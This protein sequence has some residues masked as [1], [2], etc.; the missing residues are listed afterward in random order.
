PKR[1][2]RTGDQRA[3][4]AP[5]G[6]STDPAN[7]PIQDNSETLIWSYEEDQA[8]TFFNQPRAQIRFV[9]RFGKNDFRVE[10]GG[11]DLA[12][13]QRRAIERAITQPNLTEPPAFGA[14]QQAQAAPVAEA[15][16]VVQ[17]DLTTEAFKNAVAQLKGSGK[18]DNRAFVATGEFVTAEGETFVPV[19]VYVPKSSGITPKEGQTFFGVIE[20][21]NGKS[22]L[23]FEE[24]AKLTASRDDYFV[25]KSITLP[26]GKHRGYFGIAE[27]GTPVVVT[28]VDM[29]L[30]G[31]LDKDATAASQLILSN[32]V[33]PLTEAQMATDPFAF[34]GLKV[35]PKADKTFRP[36]DEL[37]YFVELRNPGLPEMIPTADAPAPLPN[38]Q[39]KLDVEGTETG[40]KK[41]KRPAPPMEIEAI[42]L[43]GVPG[44]YGVGNAIP[45]S[46][47][48]PGEYTF[49]VKIIDTIKKESYTLS[50]KFKVVE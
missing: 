50:E 46:S 37:W 33:Y 9:D 42:P 25:D 36:A 40:G 10:R 26:A 28:A 14:P 1:I 48:K 38:I 35:V 41:V 3:G 49:T 13:A 44:H 12:A 8:R 2:Q 21:A 23:A 20:D 27:N 19:S 24:P 16:P 47:F 32:N 39:V 4:A 30:K 5:S 22:V 29:E 45:L 7:T 31:T 43:K 18:S 11:V 6:I 15:A 17:T 34:G